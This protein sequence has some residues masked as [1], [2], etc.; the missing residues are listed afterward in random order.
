MVP[1]T[2]SFDPGHSIESARRALA[3]RLRS[4]GIEESA[5]DARLLVGAALELDLTGMVTQAARTLTPEETAR[6]ERYAQ[7]RLAHEPVA[8]I[9]GAREF[10]GM[11]FRLSEAT[12]VPR[13]DTETVVELALEIFR[14]LTISGRRPRIADIGVGSGAI[15]LALLHEI[16]D[17]FGIGTDVS[18]AALDTARDN[19]AALG[20][21]DRAA[22]VACSYASALRGPFDLIVSNPPYIPS[23]EIPTL[24]VEVREHDPHLA[25]DGGNDGYDAYR[26]LIPQAAERLAPGGALIVEAGQGQARNIETLMA[27]AGLTLDRPAKADLAGIPRAV[28][29]RKMPP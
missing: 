1:L 20:L 11:P 27:A 28:S 22:F 25:L 18:L 16:P 14:G 24:S 4:A 13:P 15:L 19:A 10:W 21:G 9:L 5:L 7:R 2:T 23:A 3:A 29:A 12:L 8:R 6:L 17:A 26:A